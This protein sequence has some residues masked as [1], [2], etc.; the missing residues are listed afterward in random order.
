[1]VFGQVGVELLVNSALQD[2][3]DDGYDGYRTEVGRVGWIAGFKDGMNEGVF[4]GLWDIGLGY[5]GVEQMQEHPTD[6][7]KTLAEHV[8]TDAVLTAG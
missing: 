6:R 8:N 1:M 5:A 7:V 4:P 3:G 2:F